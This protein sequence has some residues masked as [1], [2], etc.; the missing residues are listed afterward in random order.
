MKS[1]AE[2]V[3]VAWLNSASCASPPP[4][5]LGDSHRHRH[6]LGGKSEACILALP[7]KIAGL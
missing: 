7:A 2:T 3:A 1:S 6:A 4:Q 5:K